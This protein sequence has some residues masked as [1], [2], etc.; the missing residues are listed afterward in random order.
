MTI[1]KTFTLK[2]DDDMI[3][4]IIGELLNE[5]DN[6]ASDLLA[7]LDFDEMTEYLDYRRKLTKEIFDDVVDKLIFDRK[8]AE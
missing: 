8:G 1:T 4:N 2:A 5:C 3:D 7:G 6:C